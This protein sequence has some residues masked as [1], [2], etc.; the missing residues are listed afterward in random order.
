[1]KHPTRLAKPAHLSIPYTGSVRR[2]F[3][4]TSDRC[5]GASGRAGLP[6]VYLQL[7][8]RALAL[9]QSTAEVELC[10]VRKLLGSMHSFR[11]SCE[12]AGIAIRPSEALPSNIAPPH[13]L[14][15]ADWDEVAEF[16]DRI[17]R[18][19]YSVLVNVG[20]SHVDRLVDRHDLEGV[21]GSVDDAVHSLAGVHRAKGSI[22]S[23][24]APKQHWTPLTE[25]QF[26]ALCDRLTA[27]SESDAIAALSEGRRRYGGLSR[28]LARAAWLTGMR[29]LEMFQCRLLEF[30]PGK[31][32]R[33]PDA[34]EIMS[35]PKRAFE[36]GFLRDADR[37]ALNG[38]D[39]GG[40]S[41]SFEA[42]KRSPMLAVRTLKTLNSSPMIENSVRIL[43]LDGVPPRDL[44]TLRNASLLGR[45]NLPKKR[46]KELANSCSTKLR[47]ASLELFPERPVPVTL[48]YLRHAFIDAARGTMRPEE[49]AALSGHT[50]RDTLA[51]YG[52][53]SAK[54]RGD[55]GSGRWMPAPDP[56][57]VAEI[58]SAWSLKATRD[59]EPPPPDNTATP[60]PEPGLM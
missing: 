17:R 4:A 59:A 31:L 3:A 49:V 28:L 10:A 29:S 25:S 16:T 13:W 57:Y 20:Q 32:D 38:S 44:E 34:V 27:G 54:G 48:H 40:G 2:V 42:G 60:A 45:L 43:I 55:S 1:M 46:A 39:E 50:S 26:A 51:R 23:R 12:R 36:L 8:L 18:A 35:S 30:D 33:R 7:A 19:T 14:D 15:N 24:R 56:A 11:D 58:E 21:F 9:A 37:R 47:R 22:N 52:G 6:D 53:K 5:G 41:C